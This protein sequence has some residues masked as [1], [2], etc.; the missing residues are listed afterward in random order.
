MEQYAGAGWRLVARGPA[1]GCRAAAQGEKRLAQA[2]H[3]Q[4]SACRN[5]AKKLPV[6]DFLA[7]EFGIQ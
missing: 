6:Y 1:G 4:A 2:V 3:G 7:P 5:I